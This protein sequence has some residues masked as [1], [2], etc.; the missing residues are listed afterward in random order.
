M[1]NKV[2]YVDIDGTICDTQGVEYADAKPIQERIGAINDLY[3]KGNTIIYWTARGTLS[4]IDYGPLTRRQLQEWGCL[5]HGLQ[6]GKPV[7]DLYI[8]DK[9]LNANDMEKVCL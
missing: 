9:A 7:F 3:K 8:C 5:Y 4:G 1:S 6:F 2:I